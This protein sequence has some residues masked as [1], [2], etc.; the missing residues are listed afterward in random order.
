MDK[1]QRKVKEN[2]QYIFTIV[3]Q[4]VAQRMGKYCS[5][6]EIGTKRM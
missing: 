4:D 3:G 2:V 1:S 5:V 6:C